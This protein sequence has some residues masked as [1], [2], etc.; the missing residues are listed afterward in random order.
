MK[1]KKVGNTVIRLLQGD[2]T[3]C[4][5][6]A[7]VNA[8]NQELLMERGVAGAI[9]Q[10]GGD[11]IAQEAANQAPIK[12]GEAIVTTGGNL[13]AK[14]V[15]HAAGVEKDAKTTSGII[16]KAVKN[17]LK[18]AREHQMNSL[19]FPAIGTG[20]G[21]FPLDECAEAMLEEVAKAAREEKTVLEK[22]IFAFHDQKS[23]KAFEQVLEQME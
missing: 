17:T 23:Y 13:K 11:A 6:D 16:R 8:A 7:V 14:Y 9:K 19:A 12:I 1:E 2:I 22:V 4:D 20:V 3:T 10:A 15:I 21:G 5:V 18:R